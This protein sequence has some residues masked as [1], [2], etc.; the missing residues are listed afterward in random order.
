M[1]GSILASDI[2]GRK[3]LIGAFVVGRATGGLFESDASA[4]GSE[5]R[6]LACEV[7]KRKKEWVYKEEKRGKKERGKVRKE[8]YSHSIENYGSFVVINRTST[9]IHFF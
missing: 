3:V 7:K 5:K 9:N 8:T 4:F 1:E 6:E 2:F